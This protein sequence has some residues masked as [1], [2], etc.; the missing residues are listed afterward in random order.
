M[1]WTLVDSTA[2]VTQGLRK[3]ART[4]AC[5]NCDEQI[6]RRYRDINKCLL[7]RGWNRLSLLAASLNVA[8]GASAAAI[9]VARI[10]RTDAMEK[11]AAATDEKA[12]VW[13]QV[14]LATN[15]KNNAME[16]QTGANTALTIATNGAKEADEDRVEQRRRCAWRLVRWQ[17]ITVAMTPYLY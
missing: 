2:V 14:A 1:S 5:A 9:A 11:E 13:K 6:A 10:A 4:C 15:A 8:E 3:R 17:F 12:E 16:R 7:F